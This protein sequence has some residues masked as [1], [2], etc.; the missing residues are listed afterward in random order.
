MPRKI[1][2][3]LNTRLPNPVLQVQK[4]LNDFTPCLWLSEWG[5][6]RWTDWFDSEELYWLMQIMVFIIYQIF[7]LP[8]NGLEH[9][10]PVHVHQMNKCREQPGVQTLAFWPW[11][12]KYPVLRKT[13][14]DN[15]ILE[16]YCVFYRWCS[17]KMIFPI[18]FKIQGTQSR[19]RL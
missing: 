9:P 6:M 15:Y 18:Q 8:C 7:Y 2:I 12:L 11:Y 5:P 13:K 10:K 19:L 4:R 1:R 16:L 14:K 17:L 3:V